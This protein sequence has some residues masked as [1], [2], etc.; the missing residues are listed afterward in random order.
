MKVKIGRKNYRIGW[1]H[2]IGRRIIIV[3]DRTLPLNGVTHCYIKD[4]KDDVVGFGS[5]NCSASD[6]FNRTTGREISLL[7]AMKE[8][9]WQKDYRREVWMEVPSVQKRIGV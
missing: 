7:R 6:N 1:A 8:A 4:S 3:G 9:G 5:A 2:D